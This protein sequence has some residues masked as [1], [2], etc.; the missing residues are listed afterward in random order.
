MEKCCVYCGSTGPLTHD[1]VPPLVAFPEQQRPTN[2]I[3]VPACATC[4]QRFSKEDEEFASYLSVFVGIDTHKTEKL[5]QKSIRI[6][7]HNKRIERCIR[8]GIRRVWVQEGNLITGTGQAL[9][10]PADKHDRMI[11]RFIKALYYHCLKRL[12]P[13]N[14]PV[15]ATRQQPFTGKLLDLWRSWPGENIGDSGEF[16]Y[17]Y[18]CDSN[19]PESSLDDDLL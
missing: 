14:I 2:L 15:L 3:T 4:N 9:H 19:D 11:I 13:L 17:R 7:S 1:H 8:S 16:R 6:V 12:L 18:W 5:H 10:W